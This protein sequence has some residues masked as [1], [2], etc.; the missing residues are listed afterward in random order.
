MAIAYK[1]DGALFSSTTATTMALP[2]P[3][4]AVDDYVV[5]VIVAFSAGAVTPPSGWAEVGTVWNEAS[6]YYRTFWKKATGSASATTENFVMPVAGGLGKA[7]VYTG[8]G[9]GAPTRAD[10]NNA[11]PAS[12][13]GS[14]TISAAGTYSLNA[15]MFASRTPTGTSTSGTITSTTTVRNHEAPSASGLTGFRWDLADA[16]VTGSPSGKVLVTVSGGTT[17]SDCI[18]LK[19]PEVSGDVTDPT[20]SVTAPTASATLT[21]TSTFT[22]TATDDTAVTGVDF[23]SDATLL[24]H[25][26]N[27]SGT[28]WSLSVDSTTITDGSHTI[29]AV[30]SDAAG[31]TGTSSGVAVTVDNSGPTNTID[32]WDGTTDTPFDASTLT[33]WYNDEEYGFWY[34]VGAPV[35]K[36]EYWDG[37]TEHDIDLSDAPT[38]SALDGLSYVAVGDSYGVVQ[39]ASGVDYTSADLFPQQLAAALG[40]TVTNRH[41]NSYMAMDVAY[42][43]NNTSSGSKWVVGSFQMMTAHVGGNDL[44]LAGTA[45]GLREYING[46]EAIIALLRMSSRI[47]ASSA[48]T[49]GTWSSVGSSGTSGGARSATVPNNTLTF[50]VTGTNCSVILLAPRDTTG[51]AYTITVDGGAPISGTTVGQADTNPVVSGNYGLVPIHLRNMGAGTHSVVVKH[52]GSSGN[53]LLVDSVAVWGS[54]MPYLLIAASPWSEGYEIPDS[55]APTLTKAD[56]EIYRNALRDILVE[57]Q[58]TGKIGLVL[59]DSYD[60]TYWAPIAAG[61]PWLI[62]DGMHPNKAGCDKLAEVWIGNARRVFPG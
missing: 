57:H 3:A 47:L 27:T 1:A 33:F 36:L 59:P 48:T 56:I 22:A 53:T 60:K 37:T 25:A 58:D 28:T 10:I 7:T 32:Y 62:S 14:P 40:T 46:V 11:T 39:T 9:N 13:W 30:A 5:A 17:T 19:I 2:I 8:A 41:V 4:L 21:G 42:M 24:G 54:S 26:T 61:A 23:Y 52:A 38:T 6:L 55:G 16:I 12:N 29:T 44:K 34:P 15:L 31:N 43:L 50:S 20:V 45:T 35:N 49:G 18:M 51:C